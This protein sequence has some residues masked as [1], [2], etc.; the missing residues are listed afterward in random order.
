MNIL[1]DDK[2]VVENH[3]A[4][5]NKVHVDQTDSVSNNT[6]ARR[7]RQLW[8]PISLCVVFSHFLEFI[9]KN[10]T[11]A[12]VQRNTIAL[13]FYALATRKSEFRFD[14][15]IELKKSWRN[16]AENKK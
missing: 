15:T 14:S 2:K 7:G 11:T 4:K 13:E 5:K 10:A 12:E 9:G 8:N 1:R 3:L 16:Q 6:A